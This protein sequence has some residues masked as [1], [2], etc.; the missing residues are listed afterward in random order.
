MVWYQKGL[1]VDPL[2]EHFYQRLM[3]CYYR[4]GRYAEA[5]R[6][7]G[8]CREVLKNH[9]DV[10]PAKATEDLYRRIRHADTPRARSVDLV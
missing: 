6:V 5:A 1:S 2:E 3:A 8:R 4:Q 7:Y 9:F 10:P